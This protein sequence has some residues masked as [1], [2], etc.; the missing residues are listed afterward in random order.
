MATAA[1]VTVT[2]R[3]V[4]IT[5]LHSTDNG[6]SNVHD[7]AVDP[8]KGKS[9]KEFKTKHQSLFFEVEDYYSSDSSASSPRKAALSQSEVESSPTV[10]MPTMIVGAVNF[11]EEFVSMKATLERLSKES[12]E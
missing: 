12:A 2:K 8:L 1:I 3:A 10:I 7:G 9:I 4:G 6:D 11:E 5:T